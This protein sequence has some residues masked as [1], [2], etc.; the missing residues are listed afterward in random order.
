MARKRSSTG[1]SH[2]FSD[3][4]ILNQWLLSL[5][6]IDQIQAHSEQTAGI[7]PFHSLAKPIRDSIEGLDNDNLHHYFHDLIESPVFF[8]ENCQLSVNQIQTYEENIVR[9]TGHL[10]AKRRNPI[11]WKYFQWLSILFVEIYLDYFFGNRDKLLIQLNEFLQRFNKREVG[12]TNISPYREEDL[13]KLC[14]QNATGSG[15]TLLMHV[16]IL[17]YRYYLTRQ[18]T[19]LSLSRV[20]LLTPHDRLSRQHLT[21]LQL[22]GI[23]AAHYLDSRF[24]MFGAEQGLQH[25]DVLEITKLGDEDKDKMIATRVLGDQNLLL[26]DEGHRGMSSMEEGVWFSRRA[27]LCAKGFTFEYSATFEQ[28]VKAANSSKFENSYAKAVIFDYSYRWFYEDGFGKNY[29]ILN[30]PKSLEETR[31]IYLTACLLKFYQQ[32]RIY[33]EKN[34]A[35]LPFHLDS[36]LW[37]FVGNTVTRVRQSNV[38]KLMATDVAIVVKFIAEFVQEQELAIR[39]IHSILNETGSNT[40]LLDEDNNDIFEGAF[41][42]LISTLKNGQNE[43]TMYQDI[44]MRLFHS[45]LG[46]GQLTLSRITG[47]SGEI[48]L[49]IEGQEYPFGLIS[50][51]DAKGLCEHIDEIASQEQINLKIQESEFKDSMFQNVSLP[52]SRINLL[53]GS[54][55]FVEGWDCWRV[56]TM[57]L[58]HV[59]RTEGAQII[60]LFGRGVRL[61]GYEWSLKRSNHSSAINTPQYIEELETLNVF[62]VGAD[63][64][65]NFREFLR[66]EGLHGYERYQHFR[67]PL[68][69][70]YDF[71]KNIKVLRPKLNSRRGDDYNFH[72]DAPSVT[73]GAVP[74]F[75]VNNKVEVD[76]YPHIKSIQSQ[77]HT[78][79]VE[80][81]PVKL[82]KE[83][84]AMINYD[85]LYI[86]IERYKIQKRWYNLNVSKEGIQSLLSGE[87]WYS[88]KLPHTYLELTKYKDVLTLQQIVLELLKRYC[89]RLYNYQKRNFF[90]PRLEL[91]E[92]GRDDENIPEEDFYS[93]SVTESENRVIRDIRKISRELNNTKSRLLKVGDFRACNFDFHVYQPLLFVRPDRRIVVKPVS[94]NESEYQFV[95]DLKLWYDDQ[96]AKSIKGKEFYLL[97]NLSKGRGIGFFEAEN[98]HPDFILWL[99][100]E[101]KQYISFVEPH[102]MGREGPGSEKVNFFR[103]I[104]AIESRLGDPT[105]VLNSFILSW[106]RYEHLSHWGFS[107]EKFED[108]HVLF[109]K[110]DRES[111]IQKLI[112]K[113]KHGESQLPE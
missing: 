91:R 70:T 2:K 26:V 48:L 83:L 105:V 71:G 6:G 35:F 109:M 78:I 30:L 85:R 103:R 25:I 67:I 21:E 64:M 101:N 17:Q 49:S 107:K 31:T 8:G 56:S 7:L 14:L 92:L 94:L 5:F 102:G 104:K 72:R 60:Q 65:E 59:G 61:K 110:D 106:S 95:E 39:H 10:N 100:D 63:F 80:K 9:H 44:L 51:G 3:K 69:I 12:Y 53:I 32:L 89:E 37:I 66:E 33:E 87:N 46:S 13:N 11:V 52:S 113:M 82:R 27:Q 18:K 55:K 86:E 97:R 68:N 90:E 22:S 43:S 77:S 54:K 24:G 38:T 20:I 73:V 45:Q 36:P 23:S 19:D 108:S 98:F 75:L 42:Y 79:A 57:G 96:D 76:W 111:Y 112:S 4:L 62:G 41:E 15:K 29:Q 1:R 50:V 47:D 58:M 40:G 28:A 81:E 84:V 34:R 88:L 16:N 99:I 93:V 74:N